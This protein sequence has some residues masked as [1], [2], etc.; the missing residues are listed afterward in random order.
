MQ[1]TSFSLRSCLF[2]EFDF[3]TVEPV[4]ANQQL[5]ERLNVKALSFLESISREIYYHILITH[6]CQKRMGA[7][8]TRK[9]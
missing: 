6:I 5:T 4:N 1:K 8:I 9:F 2:S 7:G 3:L